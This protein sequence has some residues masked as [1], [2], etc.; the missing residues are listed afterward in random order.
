MRD[1]LRYGM[2][3]MVVAGLSAGSLALVY[4]AT[5]GRRKQIVAQEKRDALLEVLPEASVFEPVSKNQSE[6]QYYIGYKTEDKKVIAG[7]AC[8][9]EGKGYSST[10]RTM[11]GF[12]PKGVITGLKVLSQQETP[13]LGA[14]IEEV[15]T[16]RSLKD[17]LLRREDGRKEEDSEKPW[18]QS[19]FVGKKPE[20][21]YV[22]KLDA[23]T[24]ATI[25]SKAVIDSVREKVKSVISNQ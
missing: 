8:I 12:D 18:F 11:V 13:G 14:R 16:S 24:G 9:A 17:V 10:I 19:Q 1:I 22:E 21:L 25:T 7:Y 15:K 5:E 3:L 4:K 20:D 6:V 2:I 23:I